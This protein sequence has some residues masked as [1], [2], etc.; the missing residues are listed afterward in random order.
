MGDFSHL[1]FSVCADRFNKHP[2]SCDDDIA[3][4]KRYGYSGHFGYS[5]VSRTVVFNSGCS[6]HN[7][8][9]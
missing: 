9:N 1:G 2:R 3:E 6:S 4:H 5:S 8:G 7:L